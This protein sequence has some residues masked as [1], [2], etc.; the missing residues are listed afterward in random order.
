MGRD[1][2]FNTF[3]HLLISMQKTKVVY[4]LGSGAT[5]AEKEFQSGVEWDKIRRYQQG[6]LN[7][8]VSKRVITNMEPGF[9]KKYGMEDMVGS[10]D[11]KIDEKK[12]AMFE[13]S[14]LSEE[15]DIEFLITLIDELEGNSSKDD[16]KQLKGRYAHEI[17]DKLQTMG[18]DFKP[19]LHLAM[20]EYHNLYAE[21][22]ELLGIL[23]LNYDSVLEDAIMSVG[24]KVNFGVRCETEGGGTGGPSD[25]I[26]VLKLHGSFNWRWDEEKRKITIVEDDNW[27]DSLW[28]GPSVTK[29]YSKY[30]YSLI[31][32]KAKELLLECDELRIVGC[33]LSRNDLGILTLLFSSQK[34]KNL[35][36][37]NKEGYKIEL[38][39]TYDGYGNITKR[40][41]Y[42]L[43]FKDYFYGK[44]HAAENA[45]HTWLVEKAKDLKREFGDEKLKGTRLSELVAKWD[46]RWGEEVDE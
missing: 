34:P 9:L 20:L 6:L 28:I 42:A 7:R 17:M 5:H 29:I 44:K 4:L 1:C 26:L 35:N 11:E 22:E 27:E 15:L 25:E 41:D 23:T 38:I 32:G 10:T 12:R 30:P 2:I 13:L 8:D 46:A 43:N 40:L 36:G 39:S 19:S 16:S 33:S 3:L 24:K 21:K 37:G 18:E 14:K 31:F 45:F